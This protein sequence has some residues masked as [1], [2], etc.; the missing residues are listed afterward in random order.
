[1]S[2][3]TERL[4]IYKPNEDGLSKERKGY[5][6]KEEEDK[7]NENRTTLTEGKKRSIVGSSNLIQ[8]TKD[9]VKKHQT[10]VAKMK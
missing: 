4:A 1:M 2:P 9:I 10:Q 5:D 8:T 6:S 7:E 3:K